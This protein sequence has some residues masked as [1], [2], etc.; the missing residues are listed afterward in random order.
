MPDNTESFVLTRET[1][2]VY[3]NADFTEGR[4]PMVPTGETFATED[5]AWEAVGNRGGVQGCTADGARWGPFVKQRATDWR[6][7]KRIAG[8]PG[9]Y[10]VRR[11]LVE[12]EV[13]LSDPAVVYELPLVKPLRRVVREAI[14]GSDRSLRAAVAALPASVRDYIEGQS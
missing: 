13:D 2:V 3:R 7:W 1:W 10:D 8:F 4:G 5:A 6:D 14:S 11:Q 9:D 12:V